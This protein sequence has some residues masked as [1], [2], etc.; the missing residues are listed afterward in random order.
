MKITSDD[1]NIFAVIIAIESYR[2]P[3]ISRVIYAENDANAF[4]NLL[5][6]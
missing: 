1:K 2:Y 3:D 5:T 4:Q 6:M